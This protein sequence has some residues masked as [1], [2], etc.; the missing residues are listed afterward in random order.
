MRRAAV[1]AYV[2]WVP[3]LAG[4]ALPIQAEMDQA[5]G[6]AHYATQFDHPVGPQVTALDRALA[7]CSEKTRQAETACVRARV[8]ATPTRRAVIAMVPH[9]REGQLCHYDQTTRDQLGF[10]RANATTYEKHWRIDLDFRKP[11]PDA[12]HVPLTVSDRDDFDSAP[13]GGAAR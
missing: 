4:C 9:C 11:A 5:S 1:L 8:D 12:A 2:L 7:E 6:V 3:L 13:A 10:V